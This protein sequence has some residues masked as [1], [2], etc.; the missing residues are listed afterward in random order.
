MENMAPNLS[1]GLKSTVYLEDL[2]LTRTVD[3]FFPLD[4]Q[5]ESFLCNLSYQIDNLIPHLGPAAESTRN[6]FPSALALSE[7]Y[8]PLL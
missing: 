5:P 8:L 4:E 1:T 3:Q 2:P 6:P 7:V